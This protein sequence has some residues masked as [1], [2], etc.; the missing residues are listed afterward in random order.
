MEHFLFEEPILQSFAHISGAA[1]PLPAELTKK[2]REQRVA[3][4]F[5]TMN[6]RAF[7]GQLELEIFSDQDESLVSLQRRLAE[8][9]VPHD[10]PDKNDL[11]PLLQ[12][13]Q[14]S[15]NDR[16]LCRYRYL[17]GEVMSADIY[18]MF[19][20]AGI[21]DQDKM[22]ELGMRLRK[23]M[24]EP[25]GLLEGSAFTQFRGRNMSPDA[26]L[27]MYKAGNGTVVKD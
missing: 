21:E 19:Q 20:E 24:L 15:A 9:Y 18:C 10:L 1:E 4:K 11:A 6:Q 16:N 14:D 8:E 7:L 5:Q 25:G 13:M 12:V 22:R 27:A 17:W 3:E 2:L 23:T 26:V